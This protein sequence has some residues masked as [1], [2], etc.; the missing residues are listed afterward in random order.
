M[1][2]SVSL[3]EAPLICRIFE[4]ALYLAVHVG[5]RAIPK[6]DEKV[7]DCSDGE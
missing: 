6:S 3:T 1:S 5:E 7:E 4:G 2:N